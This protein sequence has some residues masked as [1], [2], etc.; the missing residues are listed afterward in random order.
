MRPP[1]ALQAQWDA[2]LEADGFDDMD[3]K[4]RLRTAQP[5]TVR[6][7]S[8][9]TEY[10]RLATEY[11]ERGLFEDPFER[12]VWAR[13]AEGESITDI[14]AAMVLRYESGREVIRAIIAKHAPFVARIPALDR[15]T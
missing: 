5:R 11:L 6:V 12:L 13:H 4:G 10:Y 1:R 14:C 7:V 9:T 3:G 2:I 15:L 8:A